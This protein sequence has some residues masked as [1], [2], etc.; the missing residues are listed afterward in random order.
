VVLPQREAA[1]PRKL[2]SAEVDRGERIAH[3]GGAVAARHR[4]AQPQLPVV[5]QPPTF[6]RGGVENGAGVGGTGVHLHRVHPR[7]EIHRHHRC[8]GHANAADIG[9][10]IAA[11]QLSVNV[12]PPAHR[13]VGLQQRTYK[14]VARRD[15]HRRR[16]KR[17]RG[18]GRGGLRR[19]RILPQLTSCVATPA[20]DGSTRAGARET[21]SQRHL[22]DAR[23]GHPRKGISHRIRQA[24]VHIRLVAIPQLTIRVVTPALHRSILEP[25]A[26]VHRGGA[27]R[28]ILARRQIFAHRCTRLS[29]LIQVGKGEGRA[30]GAVVDRG[31]TQKRSVKPRRT[32]AARSEPRPQ[33]RVTTQSAQRRRGWRHRWTG[34]RQRHGGA[35]IGYTNPLFGVVSV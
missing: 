25:C 18:H 21:K 32:G 23:Q 3:G 26:R 20:V 13:G 34:C 28:G 2:A 12:A 29:H 24:A 14:V 22:V 35:R 8:H 9:D 30:G 5:V 16:G 6:H 17:H 4:V 27:A 31:G 11:P 1:R 7:A 10:G 33:S 19:D 15:L